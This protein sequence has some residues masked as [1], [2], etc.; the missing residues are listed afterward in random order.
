MITLV[1]FALSIFSA[2]LCYEFIEHPLTLRAQ[3]LAKKA[4]QRHAPVKTSAKV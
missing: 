2:W 1:M 4:L 3:A